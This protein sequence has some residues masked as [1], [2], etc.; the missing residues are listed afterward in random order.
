MRGRRLNRLTTRPSSIQFSIPSCQE[1]TE[2]PKGSPRLSVASLARTS[3]LRR[4]RALILR[5][6]T[7]PLFKC[8]VS[9][10]HCY[11]SCNRFLRTFYK[12]FRKKKKTSA[13]A[14]KRKSINPLLA[15]G[16]KQANLNLSARSAQTSSI[17]FDFRPRGYFVDY[18][19]PAFRTPQTSS[20]V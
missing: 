17:P 16:N 9:I 20:S 7:R 14:A 3:G 8:S 2:T 6:T 11:I 1:S 13:C 4:E 5:L 10:T 12:N 19:F 18:E 15:G